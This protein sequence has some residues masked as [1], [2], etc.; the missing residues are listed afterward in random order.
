H[1]L[2]TRGANADVQRGRLRAPWIVEQMKAPVALSDLVDQLTRVVRR[3]AVDDQ[4]FD[5]TF[6]GHCECAHRCQAAR[7]E[8]FFLVAGDDN[9]DEARPS[10]MLAHNSRIAAAKLP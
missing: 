1:E 9:R 6:R 10:T 8:L 7:D 3:P 5:I 2:S 4:H